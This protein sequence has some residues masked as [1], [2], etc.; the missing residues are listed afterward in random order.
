MIPPTRTPGEPERYRGRYQT[1]ATSIGW[2]GTCPACGA[3]CTWTASTATSGAPLCAC[4]TTDLE[5]A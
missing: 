4:P 1:S 2:A 5:S 3:D